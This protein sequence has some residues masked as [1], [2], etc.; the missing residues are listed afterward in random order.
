MIPILCMIYVGLHLTSYTYVFMIVGFLS[1]K[2]L[3]VVLMVGR[4]WVEIR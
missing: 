4:E 2:V 3:A 1:Y